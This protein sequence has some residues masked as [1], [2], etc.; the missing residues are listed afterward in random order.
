MYINCLAGIE[1]ARLIVG[2]FELVIIGVIMIMV[3]RIVEK[4][5]FNYCQQMIEKNL[6]IILCQLLM[7][8]LLNQKTKITTNDTE[9]VGAK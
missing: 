2:E 7:V 9:G 5:T 4:K 8:D 3:I 1:R 6:N